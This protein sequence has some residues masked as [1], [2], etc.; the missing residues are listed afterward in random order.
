VVEN[1][2]DLDLYLA[3]REAQHAD[4]KPE[5]G[6]TAEFRRRVVGPLQRARRG[7]TFIDRGRACSVVGLRYGEE[8]S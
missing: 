7:M 3:R 5:Q 8:T 1:V 4:V 2:P 6:K